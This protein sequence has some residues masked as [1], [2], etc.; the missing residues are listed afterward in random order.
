MT[1]TT[2]KKVCDVCGKK[3]QKDG[4][5]WYGGNVTIEENYA[6]K[7]SYPYDKVT[8]DACRECL[9]VLRGFLKLPQFNPGLTPEEE[10]M[11]ERAVSNMARR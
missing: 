1:E 4:P 9:M 3:M 8:V 11:V 7:N 2:T 5:I 10:E 6:T